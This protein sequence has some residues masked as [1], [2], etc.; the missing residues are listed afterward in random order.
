MVLIFGT[1]AINQGAVRTLA[2]VLL[3]G[4]LFLKADL[5]RIKQKLGDF[6]YQAFW[7]D[8][9]AIINFFVTWGVLTLVA[10]AYYF[11]PNKHL[12]DVSSKRS[13]A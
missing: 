5:S 9:D 6:L 1:F 10:T 2:S 12:S 13:V 4:C 8:T 7:R 11:N 3:S